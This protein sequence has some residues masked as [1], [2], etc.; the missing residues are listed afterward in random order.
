[1]THITADF[2]EGRYVRDLCCLNCHDE[3]TARLAVASPARMYV[4]SLDCGK[5]LEQLVEFDQFTE[6]VQ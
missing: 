3:V 2:D 5:C 1:M 4:V 6:V